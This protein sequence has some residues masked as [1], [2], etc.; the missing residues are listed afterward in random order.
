MPTV[1]PLVPG[2]LFATAALAAC[3]RGGVVSISRRTR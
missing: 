1:R 2:A 3:P